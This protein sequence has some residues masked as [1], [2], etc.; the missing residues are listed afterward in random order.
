MCL[1][2]QRHILKES[3]QVTE[4]SERSD[5]ASLGMRAPQL[6]QLARLVTEV[7][8]TRGC[9]GMSCSGHRVPLGGTVS[10]RAC[11]QSGHTEN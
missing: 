3:G 8:C 11:S 9:S 1:K 2:L 10:T 4:E 5:C 6:K 7:S